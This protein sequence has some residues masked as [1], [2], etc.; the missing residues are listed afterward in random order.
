MKTIQY[1][2]SKKNLV[3]FI[4]ESIE[5][6]IEEPINTF[7]DAFSGSG[8]VSYHFRNKYN[9][10]TNDKQYFSKVI[11]DAYL[12]NNRP[13]S[14][15]ESLIKELNSVP[16]E[17]FNS[18]DKFFTNNYS[19][20]DLSD[21]FRTDNSSISNYDGLQKI[22]LT[23]N[24]IKIDM[25]RTKIDNWF[26][27]LEKPIDKTKKIT[28]IE[29]NVLLL[30][31][32]LAINKVSNVVG[33][34]NGY[35]KKWSKNSKN[36]INLLIPDL[37]EIKSYTHKNYVGD[38]FETLKKVDADIT[39]YDPPYGTN[40]S[41]LVVATRYSAFYHLWNTIVLN[42]RPE[43]TG[44]AKKPAST[45]GNTQPLERNVKADTI[46]E[47]VKLI[48][49]TK[50]KYVCLSYSNKGLLT[51][52]E[53]EYVFMLGNYEKPKVYTQEHKENNQNKLAKKEGKFIDRKN[54]EEELI[55][56]LFISKR[57]E[58]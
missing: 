45:K 39:Y 36:E 20:N 53:M 19:C 22:W 56:Y 40:N 49:S 48:L 50:S 26:C 41:N 24:A 29:K 27:G 54:N 28:D 57:K 34:Q 25:I 17:Y 30:S 58:S 35:L 31:L 52:E 2:G 8:R 33:H 16:E 14:Y 9:I 10:I 55:E 38:I 13:L 43:L 44:K 3:N 51:K 18:T 11:N 4:E 46:P 5:D 7:F 1:M 15:Y 32:I 21:E 47:F 37:E 42:D 6:Y 23:K 12:C